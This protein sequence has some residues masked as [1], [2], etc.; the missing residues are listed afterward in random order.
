MVTKQESWRPPIPPS[1][2]VNFDPTPNRT[3]PSSQAGAGSDKRETMGDS[4]IKGDEPSNIR[5]KSIFMADFFKR[6]VRITI[7]YHF[8]TKQISSFLSPFK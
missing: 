1:N 2:W 4:M 5:R 6:E 7:I 3:S 8:F